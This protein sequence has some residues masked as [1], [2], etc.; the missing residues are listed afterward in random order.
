M[1][2]SE[3]PES[4]RIHFVSQPSVQNQCFVERLNRHLPTTH[5]TNLEGVLSRLCLGGP[6]SSLLLV[7]VTDFEIDTLLEKIGNSDLPETVYVALLN[8]IRDASWVAEC[9][10]HRVRGLFFRDDPIELVVRGLI[11]MIDGAVWVS[12]QTLL[13]AARHEP[14]S[15]EGD[16]VHSAV[17][18]LTRREKE[19]LGLVCVGATNQEI[20][21][22]LFISTNTVKTHIY[23][24]YK[25]IHVPNRMQAALWA[26]KHL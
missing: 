21:D 15:A 24:V 11:A 4:R 3:D 18:D 14:R 25:K 16:G 2:G 9:V 10:H 22:K 19:I 20:A 12:R 6:T 26:A 13:A 7:D 23:K 5:D 8:V 17:G 1:L